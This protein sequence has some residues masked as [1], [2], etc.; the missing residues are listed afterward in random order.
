[1]GE[2]M[3]PVISFV[4]FANSGKTTLVTRVIEELK[5]LNISVGTIKH[6]HGEL[7]LDT[8]GTDTW[9]HKA[10]GADVV[11]LATSN[12]L[13]LTKKIIEPRLE[14]ALALIIDVDIIIVEG[15]KKAK[16]PKI[17]ILRTGVHNEYITPVEELVGFATDWQDQSLLNSTGIPCFDLNNPQL[18]SKFLESKF[19]QR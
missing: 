3:I 7:E 10:S 2:A 4:G 19:I 13:Y 9:K 17:E 6:H 15:Y 12:Q 5:K 8:P 14:D 16:V 18:I 1:M 11:V